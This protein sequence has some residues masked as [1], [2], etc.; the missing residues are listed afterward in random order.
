MQVLCLHQLC[1]PSKETITGMN[2]NGRGNCF[3]CTPDRINNPNCSH[4][5]RVVMGTMEEIEKVM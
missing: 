2:E 5:Q 4:Y 1:P 3:E